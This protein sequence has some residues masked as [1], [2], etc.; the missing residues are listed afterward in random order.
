MNILTRYISLFF[1][2]LFLLVENLHAQRLATQRRSDIES[3]VVYYESV[4]A[5]SNYSCVSSIFPESLTLEELV[6]KPFEGFYFYV[7]RDAN[8]NLILRKPDNSFMPFLD[9]LV[10]IKSALDSDSD[11]LMTLFL[12][13][14][15]D[16]DWES[17]METAGLMD[18]LLEYNMKTGWPSLRSMVSTGKRLVLFSVRSNR[19]NPSWL[20]NM[21]E[22][23]VNT[24]SDWSNS[25]KK[26][27]SFD[28]KLNK[29]LSLFTDY[30][31]LGETR[32]DRDDLSAMVRRTPFLIESFKR[33][34]IRSGKVP[35][36][37]LLDKYYSWI[38][39]ALTTF[40]DFNIVYG[41][42]N[43]NG[44]PLNYV[45]WGGL[46][47][48]TGG[49]YSFPLEPGAEM[50]LSPSSPGF[51]IE[52]NIVYASASNRKNLISP[53]E[54]IPLSIERDLE[55]FIPFDNDANDRSAN[56]NK[57]LSRLVEFIQ[58]PVRGTVASLDSSARID[59]PTATTL[60]MRDH[61]FTVNVWL[62]IPK[63][64]PNKEDY[65][66]LG[67]KNFT[68]QQALH[69]MIRDQKP[70]MGFYNNDLVGNTHIEP[71]RWYNIVWRYN[72]RNG[73]QAIFVDGK[74]DAISYD[75]PVYLGADTLYVGHMD[76]SRTSDLVGMIDNLSIWSRV[77]SDKE[78][79]GVYNQLFDLHK[80]TS[81]VEW[82]FVVG[83]LAVLLF[84]LMLFLIFKLSSK[85]TPEIVN[86][87][88]DTNDDRQEDQEELSVVELPS[89]NYI[90]TFGDFHV[91]DRDGNDITAMFTPKIKQLFILILIHSNGGESGIASSDLTRL[92]WG[93]NNSSKSLKSLRSVSILK[94][95][96]ILERM[97]GI[98]ISFLSNRYQIMLTE[99]A[100]CD[101]NVCLEM[102]REN[103]V[104]TRREF[105][106]FYSIISNGEL[107]K[108]ESFDWLDDYKS[109]VC[110]STV[111]VLS[112]FISELSKENHFERLIEIA[113]QILIN[114]PCNEEALIYKIGA[115]VKQDNFRL[116]RYTYDRFSALYQE[117]YGEPF[118]T[119]FDEIIPKLA[120]EKTS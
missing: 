8:N 78:I 119:S 91:L 88:T 2:L 83:V 62:K 21:S 19:S 100:Y 108:D 42:V 118:H 48:S 4:F 66:V 111:D 61:D 32:G 43:S 77:L 59:L 10:S 79:L 97:D 57:T 18:Y 68:Y 120:P 75:R 33:A 22:F 117:M 7:E 80:S 5:I 99:E 84:I 1:C 93:D 63:Y 40:R 69:L 50:V 13:S 27:E 70:Y 98:E 41:S 9:A 90:R 87:P 102:L 47:N 28:Q 86:S 60:N 67:G 94:L 103:R 74:L 20:H 64:L 38:D 55:L 37:V 12:D 35:N 54:A 58:D 85:R 17:P 51:E 23:V 82:E 101:Y 112:R 73:E 34:W 16:Q 44:E 96:K 71:G 114:D 113:D 110:N 15:I 109:Y 65:C 52:P 104:R 26:V 105:D 49:R 45:N 6:S 30:K 14:N 3:G 56:R 25:T 106:R 95:R 81:T 115:L 89:R 36:F 31:F 53:F 46:S 116:A 72:K 92:I 24:D 11:K 39:G 76:F 29:R 107:F